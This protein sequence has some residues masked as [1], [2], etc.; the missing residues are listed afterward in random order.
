MRDRII[1]YCQENSLSYEPYLP[2]ITEIKQWS[3]RKIIREVPLFKNY[4][5]VKHDANG[6]HQIQTMPGF[7]DYISFGKYPSKIPETQI[8]QI[9]TIIEHHKNI[10]C[11]AKRFVK[12]EAVCIASGPLACYEGILIEDH[13]DSKV[14]IEVKILGQY[15]E[16]DVPIK[17]II[18]L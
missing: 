4:L 16:V 18:K 15:L 5:F 17:N 10:S 8:I 14:A 2:L 1:T 12:G 9:K 13:S 11:K 6:F 3:D 7:S